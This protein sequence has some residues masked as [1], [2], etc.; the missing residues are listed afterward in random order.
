[1]WSLPTFCGLCLTDEPQTSALKEEKSNLKGL[2]V[3]YAI[4]TAAISV[5][6]LIQKAMLQSYFCSPT[7]TWLSGWCA[8]GLEADQNKA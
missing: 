7:S 4:R 8:S 3:R 5:T 6:K 2:E 1:M